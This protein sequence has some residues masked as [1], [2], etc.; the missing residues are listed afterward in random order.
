MIHF[1]RIIPISRVKKDLGSILEFI[2]YQD[3]TVTITQKGKAVGIIMTPDQYEQLMETLEVVSDKNILA[4]LKSS[5]KDFETGKIY[6]HDEVW[7]D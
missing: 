3:E 6:T 4:T 1:D 2:S 5:R 7:Q